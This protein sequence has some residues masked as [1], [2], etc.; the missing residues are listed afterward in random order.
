M[1]DYRE[2]HEDKIMTG[3]TLG[4]ETQEYIADLVLPELGPSKGVNERSGKYFVFGPEQFRVLTTL[5]APSAQSK[6]VDYAMS[7]DEYYANQYLRESAIDDIERMETDPPLSRERDLI[8]LL[9]E[10]HLLEKEIRVA[11]F[12]INGGGITATSDFG[13]SD[14][15]APWNDHSGATPIDDAKFVKGIMRTAGG[16]TPNTAVMSQEVF[17]ELQMCEQ[18]IESLPMTTERFRATPEQVAR[19]LQIDRLIVGKVQYNVAAEDA[20]ATLTL[21]PVWGTTVLFAYI[22]Q[23]PGMRSRSLGYQFAWIPRR[24]ARPYRSNETNSDVFGI[25]ECVGEKICA[26]DCGFLATDA[27]QNG[28]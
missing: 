16:R 28:G 26:P 6:R 7:K 22:N 20:A 3:F 23:N 2:V 10:G 17:D 19:A 14:L 5:R 11:N 12:V 27:I 4:Y 24:G 18:I 1:P 21:G 8:F 25:E 15:G 13:G 9:T